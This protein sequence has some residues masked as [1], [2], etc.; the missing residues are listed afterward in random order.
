VLKDKQKSGLFQLPRTLA[1][2]LQ[3]GFFGLGAGLCFSFASVGFGG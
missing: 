1:P 2:A 3:C